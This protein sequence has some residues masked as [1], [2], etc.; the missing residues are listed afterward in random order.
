MK[1]IAEILVSIILHPIA[2]VLAWIDV[3]RRKDLSTSQRVIWI[4]VC[5]VWGIGPLLYIGVGNGKLW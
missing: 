3:L 5:A 1:I 2:M 4:V